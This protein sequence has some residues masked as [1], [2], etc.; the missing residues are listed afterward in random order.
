[1]GHSLPT[2]NLNNTSEQDSASGSFFSTVPPHFP[3]GYFEGKRIQVLKGKFRGQKFQVHQSANDWIT[4]IP[5]IKMR[6]YRAHN[7]YIILRPD[8]V[9]I[10][11]QKVSR[12]NASRTITGGIKNVESR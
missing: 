10:I 8:W 5:P 3:P 1:M 7:N 6:L 4:V 11:G 2:A 12:S 9:E